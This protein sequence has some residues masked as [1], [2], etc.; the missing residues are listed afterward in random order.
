MTTYEGASPLQRLRALGDPT[1]LDPARQDYGALGIGREHVP[2]LIALATD[3]ALRMETDDND[4]ALWAPVHA[5]RLLGQFGAVEAAE[6]LLAA[7]SWVDDYDDE[8][9]AEEL[10]LVYAELGAAAV[11]ALAGYVRAAEHGLWARV[12]AASGLEE[13]GKRHPD[14]RP[15]CVVALSAALEGFSGQDAGLNGSLVSSLVALEAV[16]AAPLIERAFA[17][18]KVD[19]MV[20][21]DWEDVQIAFGLISERTAPR[22]L[23]PGMAQ[24]A[25]IARRLEQLQ[26]RRVDRGGADF[27]EL[28]GP[29]PKRAGPPPPPVPPEIQRWNAAVDE[30]QASKAAKRAA[31]GRKRKRKRR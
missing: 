6:P 28:P 23:S 7:L 21:G 31:S 14:A 15:A 19:E 25:E 9:A 10:P 22:K 16:E 26:F 2:A 11:P 13:I 30:R 4:P 8:W 27:T 12:A 24:V 3:T 5:W 18:G 1:E 17:A 29:T 20:L